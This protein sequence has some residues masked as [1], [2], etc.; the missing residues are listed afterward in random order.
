LNVGFGNEPVKERLDWLSD[1]GDSFREQVISRFISLFSELKLSFHA[2]DRC[3][4]KRIGIDGQVFK[5]LGINVYYITIEGSV[6]DVTPA[7]QYLD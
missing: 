4:H 7:A 3:K 5:E 6:R 2:F 1:S